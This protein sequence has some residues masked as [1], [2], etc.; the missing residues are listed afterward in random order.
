[1]NKHVVQ[2]AM[3]A[4]LVVLLA[5]PAALAAPVERIVFYVH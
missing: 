5:A 4:A 1:M 2:A 3:I